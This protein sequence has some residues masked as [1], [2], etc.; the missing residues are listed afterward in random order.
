MV[1]AHRTIEMKN[2]T[3]EAATLHLAECATV[4]NTDPGETNPQDIAITS[5][6]SAQLASQCLF[7]SKGNKQW[8]AII[9]V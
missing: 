2:V 8:P 3:P 4:M 1:I 7:G 9:K 6:N 5:I